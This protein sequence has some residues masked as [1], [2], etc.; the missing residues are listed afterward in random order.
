[1]AYEIYDMNLIDS[2]GYSD[3]LPDGWRV[4]KLDDGS[5]MDECFVDMPADMDE[6]ERED[7]MA[8]ALRRKYGRVV[9]LLGYE[10]VTALYMA[11]ADE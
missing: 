9:R 5:A 3:K 11:G 7:E 10:D 8:F 6:G 1:M 4:Y 2:D